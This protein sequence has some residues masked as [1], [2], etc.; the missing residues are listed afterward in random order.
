MF[1][2]YKITCLSNNK[3]YIGMTS[4]T[5]FKRFKEHL[6]DAKKNRNNCRK[7]M[8]AIRKYDSENFSIEIIESHENFEDA[9]AA[10]IKYIKLY[11]SVNSGYNLQL[12]GHNG[13]HSEETLKLMSE[14]KKG[15]KN[16]MFGNTH[17]SAARAKISAANKG[18]N[19][20]KCWLGKSLPQETKYKIS[21]SRTGLTAGE[22]NPGAKLTLKQVGEIKELFKTSDLTRQEIA[23]MFE[24]SLSAIKRIKAGTHWK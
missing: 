12:G 16:S 24:V 18:D 10:E 15:K 11:D 19:N 17:T 21:I 7:L 8:N 9:N 20:H 13:F 5:I 2:I 1:T 22:N 3:L 23:D 14:Q 6:R 4:K